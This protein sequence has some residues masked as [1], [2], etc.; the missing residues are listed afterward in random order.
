MQWYLYYIYLY[1]DLANRFVAAHLVGRRLIYPGSISLYN[2]LVGELEV[3]CC[4]CTCMYTTHCSSI[5]QI[6]VCVLSRFIPVHWEIQ[7]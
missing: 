5:M 2:N 7:T 4:S 3:Y 1:F 6:L